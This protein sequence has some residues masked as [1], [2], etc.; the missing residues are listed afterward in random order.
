M[1]KN[2]I[3][4]KALLH[5]LTQGIVYERYNCALFCQEVELAQ[6]KVLLSSS[7]LELFMG[8]NETS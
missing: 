3:T 5:L 8:E 7:E 2:S 6:R 1:I 4:P